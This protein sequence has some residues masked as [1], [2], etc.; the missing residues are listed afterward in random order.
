[1]STQEKAAA[2]LPVVLSPE[3]VQLHK[4]TSPLE[5]RK[6]S[7]GR[8]AQLA[9][10]SKC[11]KCMELAPQLVWDESQLVWNESH[12]WLTCLVCHLQLCILCAMLCNP[13]LGRQAQPCW[14]EDRPNHGPLPRFCLSSRTCLRSSQCCNH[15]HSELTIQQISQ[16]GCP[17]LNRD[18]GG[19]AF[20]PFLAQLK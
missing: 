14:L 10:Y 16:S 8:A 4:M 15:P 19:S 5:S 3:D 2:L 17:W 7:P 18:H 1:M 12:V 6:E 13:N 20:Q 9:H 11:P